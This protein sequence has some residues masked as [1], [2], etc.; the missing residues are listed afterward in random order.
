[1]Q[2]NDDSDILEIAI[3]NLMLNNPDSDEDWNL[4]SNEETFI[5]VINSMFFSYKLTM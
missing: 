2:Q 1:M 5:M 3:S 4:I